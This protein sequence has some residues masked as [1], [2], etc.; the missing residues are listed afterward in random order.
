MFQASVG[1]GAGLAPESRIRNFWWLLEPCAKV[2][3]YCIFRYTS[4]GARE[5]PGTWFLVNTLFEFD[6]RTII[7]HSHSLCVMMSNHGEG[8]GGG[9]IGNICLF[10]P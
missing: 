7:G 5:L 3:L 10:N 1:Q 2:A 4:L 8:G 6:S 9:L